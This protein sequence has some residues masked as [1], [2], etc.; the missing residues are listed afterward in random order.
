MSCSSSSKKIPRTYQLLTPKENKHLKDRISPASGGWVHH[1]TEFQTRTPVRLDGRQFE[2][3]VHSDIGYEKDCKCTKCFKDNAKEGWYQQRW[4]CN[5]D[6]PPGESPIMQD[7]KDSM[8]WY[9]RW[10]A[11]NF[12]KPYDP[13]FFTGICIGVTFWMFS[14]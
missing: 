11:R 1:E 12:I 13:L 9:E 5:F 14:P 8:N 10:A 3:M 7:R 4:L 2:Q 6:A